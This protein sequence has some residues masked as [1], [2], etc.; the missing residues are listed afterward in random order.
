MSRTRGSPEERD[1]TRQQPLADVIQRGPRRF[2]ATSRLVR[3]VRENITDYAHPVGTCRMGPSPDANDVVDRDGRVH[4]L[5]N[6]HVADASIVPGIP[7]A[8]VNLTCFVIG[9]RVAELLVHAGH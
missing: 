6:V 5:V 9:S 3:F 1:L 8:N 4:G 2:T 7:R